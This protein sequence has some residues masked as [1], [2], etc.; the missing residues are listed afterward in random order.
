MSDLSN[1]NIEYRV[2]TKPNYHFLRRKQHV[3]VL[4]NAHGIGVWPGRRLLIEVVA[5][6]VKTSV[7]SLFDP[8]QRDLLVSQKYDPKSLTSLRSSDVQTT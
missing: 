1:T 5:Q 3:G 8:S 2:S 6:N 7:F 4:I